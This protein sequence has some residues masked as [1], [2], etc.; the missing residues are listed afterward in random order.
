MQFSRILYNLQWSFHMNV[1]LILLPFSSFVNNFKLKWWGVAGKYVHFDSVSVQT[2]ALMTYE[3]LHTLHWRPI[4]SAHNIVHLSRAYFLTKHW[5]E[6][7]I[8][9]LTSD[10][11]SITRHTQ[12][13]FGVKMTLYHVA[14][15]LIRRHFTPN[16]HWDIFYVFRKYFIFSENI[17]CVTR[18]SGWTLIHDMSQ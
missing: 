5:F 10:F 13:A 2:T 6:S 1:Y 7:K 11:F 12:R 3:W 14:S 15:T 18:K 9:F 17:F 16:A 8:L 4:D